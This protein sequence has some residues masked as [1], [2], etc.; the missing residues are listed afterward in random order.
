[1]DNQEIK[2]NELE[3]NLKHYTQPT[4]DHSL[5]KSKHIEESKYIILFLIIQHTGNLNRKK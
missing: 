5:K 2:E 1:M 3:G 4:F